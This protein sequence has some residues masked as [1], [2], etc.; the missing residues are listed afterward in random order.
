[1]S[2]KRVILMILPHRYVLVVT[3]PVSIVME[4]LILIVLIVS[5]L[6]LECLMPQLKIVNVWLDSLI[7]A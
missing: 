4:V 7:V 2:A 5:R 6:T 3:I 1:M